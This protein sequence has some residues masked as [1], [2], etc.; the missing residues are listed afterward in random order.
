MTDAGLA[1]VRRLIEAAEI[2]QKVAELG[3]RIA[4]D[5]RD[6]PLTVVGVL[7]GGVVLV[8]DLIRCIELPLRVGMI[9]ASSYRG[10]ATSPGT[11]SLDADILP[12]I[13]DR[14]V[15]VVDDIFDTGRTLT[16]V[17]ERIRAGHPRSVRGVVLLWKE[18]RR[19]VDWEPDYFGFKI[20]DVFVVGYGLDYNDE[21]R[22]LPFVAAME[23]AD[24][25]H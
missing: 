10:R 13:R 19:E 11:L 23:E 8:S 9:R 7:T 5:Y 12:D 1:D 14:D 3:R 6:R 21:H 17:V 24:F 20:P 25:R 16:S 4:A 18:N 22:S 15:L 2:Q